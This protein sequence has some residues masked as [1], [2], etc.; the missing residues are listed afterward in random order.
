MKIADI[1]LNFKNDIASVF[2]KTIELVV[3]KS[4]HYVISLT[5]S[6][7][8]IHSQN[9][10]VNVTLTVQTN[11]VKENMAHTLHWLIAQASSEKLLILVNSTGSTCCQESKFKGY[12]MILLKMC[13]LKHR[14]R[15]F[16][17]HRKVMFR[18][19]DIQV[20]VFL[21]ISWFTKSVTSQWV[22]VHETSHQTWPVDRCKQG[23]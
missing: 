16:L 12:Q 1:N 10:N 17:F 7:Q 18:S 23:L 2:A 4:G 14:L 21:A 11:L 20:F 15:I 8:I 13:H 3:T 9:S 19:Q 6:C 22:L 5:M